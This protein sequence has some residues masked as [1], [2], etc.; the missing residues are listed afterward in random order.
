MGLIDFFNDS[1]SAIIFGCGI[2]RVVLIFFNW[3]I[4]IFCTD[5]KND[6]YDDVCRHDIHDDRL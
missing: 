6:I 2:G 4:K 3:C 5:Q 1:N